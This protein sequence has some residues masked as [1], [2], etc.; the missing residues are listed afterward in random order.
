[1]LASVLK[2]LAPGKIEIDVV[3]CV[4]RRRVHHAVVELRRLEGGADGPPL[5]AEPDLGNRRPETHLGVQLAA[6][7]LGELLHSLAER[8]QRRRLFLAALALPLLRAAPLSGERLD[9]RPVAPLEPVEPRQRVADRELLRVAGEDAGHERIG[10]V[11]EHLLVEAPPDE[12]R[13]AFLHG[14]VVVFQQRLSEHRE[15]GGVGEKTRGEDLGR[16]HRDG[17]EPVLP[18]HEAAVRRGRRAHQIRLETELGDQRPQ[19]GRRRR[20]G[21]GAEVGEVALAPLGA[22]DAT[23]PVARLVDDDPIPRCFSR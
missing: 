11:V 18:H 3:G 21:V 12:P 1:M 10:D 23:E 7:R 5:F 22:D 15:L 9:Y 2:P 13:D 20:D 16:R 8:D 14:R 4:S 17:D 6:E 19:L